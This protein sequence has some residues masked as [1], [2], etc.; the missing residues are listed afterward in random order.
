MNKDDQI[1]KTQSETGTSGEE[2]V[3]NIRG[4]KPRCVSSTLVKKITIEE[5]KKQL[6]KLKL[7]ITRNNA[8]L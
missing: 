6:R 1:K 5:L 4:A 7:P 2:G 3:K 8:D